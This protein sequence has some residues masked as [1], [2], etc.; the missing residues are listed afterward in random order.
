MGDLVVTCMSRHSRNRSVGERLGR[1]ESWND[2][3][4]SMKM[5]AEGIV[6]VVSAR[7]LAKKAGI[8]MPICEQVYQIVFEKKNAGTAMRELMSRELKREQ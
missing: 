7:D 3:Q 4:A 8:E 6:T 2:I 5:V 1:G